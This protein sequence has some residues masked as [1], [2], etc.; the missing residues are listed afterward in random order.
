[1]SFYLILI[2]NYL[3]EK[4]KNQRL[5]LPFPLSPIQLCHYPHQT[6]PRWNKILSRLNYSWKTIYRCRYNSN[7]LCNKANKYS[8]S[9]YTFRNISKGGIYSPSTTQNNTRSKFRKRSTKVYSR[10]NVGGTLLP[11]IISTRNCIRH[12]TTN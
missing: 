11:L 10:K 1:M 9:I 2:T 5:T 7:F 12:N 3:F 8:P 6:A 4:L